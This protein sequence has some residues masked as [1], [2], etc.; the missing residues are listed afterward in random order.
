LAQPRQRIDLRFECERLRQG[1][2][3]IVNIAFEPERSSE[4]QMHIEA[5]RISS[6]RLRKE[7]DRAVGIIK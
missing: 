3:C 5:T 7:L 6:P 4:R 2:L 1:G